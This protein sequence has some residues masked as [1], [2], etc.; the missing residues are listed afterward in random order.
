MFRGFRTGGSLWLVV[1]LTALLLFCTRA[2][3]ASDFSP[4]DKC[5]IGWGRFVPME[6]SNYGSFDGTKF[7]LDEVG[8]DKEFRAVANAGANFVRVFPWGVW[9]NHPFGKRSQF[10]PYV[11]DIS[12]DK[13]DLSKFNGYYFPIMRRVFEIA[14]SVNLSV[15][16]CWFDACQFHGDSIKRWSP[17]ANNV[18]DITRPEEKGADQYTRAWI[19]KVLAEFGG[20]DALWSFGNEMIHASFPAFV[21]RVIVPI[22]RSKNLDFKR[23]TY[24][25][26][27]TPYPYEGNHEYSRP[28]DNPSV[29]D[30]VQGIF[31]DEF[32]LAA[33]MAVIR[34]A[35]G[36]GGPCEPRDNERPYGETLD[37]ALY[38]SKAAVRW[39]VSDD[40]VYNGNSLCDFDAQL[41]YRPAPATWGAMVRYVLGIHPNSNF[42]HIPNGPDLACHIETFEAISQAYRDL[43]GK[44][45]TNYGK[46]PPAPAPDPDRE[47]RERERRERNKEEKLR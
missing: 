47:R 4:Y 3:C 19:L 38:T 20:Y 22:V 15:M 2:G 11:L 31:E 1:Y 10:Q 27:L 12:R 34:D 45:P 21:S 44:W 36:C 16:F 35:H 30:I 40:G 5:G 46:Y 32:G 23:L 26:H 25:A 39:L 8:L 7:T 33:K 29:Q 9:G 42:E 17:W 18:Q 41:R 24:G 28:A 13:W 6:L 14:N 43:F 37:Q